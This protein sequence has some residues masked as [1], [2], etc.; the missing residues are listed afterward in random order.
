MY[1]DPEFK[2]DGETAQRFETRERLVVIGNG[3]AGCRAVEEILE[4][5]SGRYRI[6]IFGAE[7][8]VNYNRIMLSP[9]LAGEKSFEEIVLNDER[10]YASNNIE[11][12]AGDPV[13]EIDREAKLIRAKSGLE[14]GYDKLIVATGSDPF[15]IPVPGRDLPG[16]VTFRDLDDVNLML[17][18]AEAGGRAVVI[19]GGLLGLEAAYGLS[20]RGMD[21]TVLHLMPTLM[22]RQLDE[23]AGWL[24][25]QELEGRGLTIITQADTA[26]VMGEHRV[27]GVR[28]KDGREIAADLVVMAVGIKPNTALALDAGL[29]T[30]RGIKVDDHM[31]TSDPAIFAV[32][33]CV[34]HRGACYGLVAPLFEMCRSLAEGLTNEPAPYEGSVTSTKLKVSGIDVFSAGDFSGAPDS[35]DIVLR[36]ASRGIYKRL[37]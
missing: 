24:L 16:V 11:L 30:G 6:T 14:R 13:L 9:V 22:E 35:D 5:D 12:I 10:W 25:K 4:R 2:G 1:L 32:G 27:E 31:V 20:L 15:I 28:L 34:E 7:P 19:G 18:A 29:E 26:E 23:A 17:E 33:E 8:R 3:M 36:D 21:V 37:V